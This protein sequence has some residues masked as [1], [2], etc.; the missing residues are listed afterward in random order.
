MNS[1]LLK[2]ELQLS[3]GKLK[4]SAASAARY[5]RRE[6]WHK[7]CILRANARLM[8]SPGE[9]LGPIQFPKIEKSA[10]SVLLIENMLAVTI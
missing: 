2:D 3:M 7:L 10:R 4:N 1:H 5:T 9:G 8:K 6:R